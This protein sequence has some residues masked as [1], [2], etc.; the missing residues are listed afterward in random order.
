MTK[1]KTHERGLKFSSLGFI[2]L[3]LKN[4]GG[5]IIDLTSA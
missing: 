5:D 4:K 1:N 3:D 2:S